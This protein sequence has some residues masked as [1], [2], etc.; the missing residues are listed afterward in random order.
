M[1]Y[2]TSGNKGEVNEFMNTGGRINLEKNNTDISSIS[3]GNFWN[4]LDWIC[5]AGPRL[6]TP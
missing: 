6:L 5:V 2:G 4:A 3:A 1:Q